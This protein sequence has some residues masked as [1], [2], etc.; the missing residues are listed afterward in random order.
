MIG[1]LS[2]QLEEALVHGGVVGEFGM[3]SGSENMRFLYQRGLSGIFGEHGHSG[4]DALENWSANKHHFHRL[5]LQRGRPA[6]HIAVNLPAV[7]IPEHGHV[8]QAKR[9]LLRILYFGRQQNRAGTG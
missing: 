8:Q 6:D 4:S 5:T 3:K 9:F 1:V 2:S 7:S